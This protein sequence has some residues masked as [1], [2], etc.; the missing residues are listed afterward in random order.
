MASIIRQI[1]ID[2]RPGDVWEAV[3]DVG[4]LHERLVPGFVVDTRVEPGA[5]VVTFGDGSVV[6]ELLVGQDDD[7]RRLAW[8][9]TGGMSTH[10]NASAQVLD[11]GHGGTEFVWITDVLP[12]ELADPIRLRMD[13]GLAVI[14]VTMEGG[15]RT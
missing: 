1:H 3:R 5:R 10:H 14:K 9:A 8:S 6:R 15:P 7:H 13:R 4:A 11:D 12:D 2:A